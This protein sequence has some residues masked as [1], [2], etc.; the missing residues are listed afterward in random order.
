MKNIKIKEYFARWKAVDK[1]NLKELRALTLKERINQIIMLTS[2]LDKIT[3]K[4]VYKKDIE[5][6]IIG[7]WNILKNAYK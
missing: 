7:R 6:E 3:V 4:N 2:G 1:I 5:T